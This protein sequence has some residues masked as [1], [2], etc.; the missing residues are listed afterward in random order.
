M[1]KKKRKNIYYAITTGMFMVILIS[2][3]ARAPVK[4]AAERITLKELCAQNNVEWQWDSLSQVVTLNRQ[5]LEA[6]VLIG[7]H[8]VNVRNESI[9]LSAPVR[10]EYGVVIVPPDFKKRVIDK[11][12]KDRPYFPIRK[13]KNIVLDPGH[14]G[15]DPGA[16]GI[17]GLYEKDVVLDIAKRLK[18]NL[19]QN[20]FNV[21]MTRDKDVFIPLDE[22][23]NFA[24]RNKADLFISIHANAA[25]ARGAHGM[26]AYYSKR[27]GQSE[28]REV[29]SSE[30][31]TELFRRLNM[32]RNSLTL[33]NI[34]FDMLYT[35]KQK[36]SELLADFILQDSSKAL[37]MS[38]RG[39]Q[40]ADFRVLRKTLVPAVLVEVGF[41]S[42]KK[43]EKMLMESSYRQRIADRLADSILNYDNK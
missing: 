28:I 25:P 13:F 41:L 8:L 7:S 11:L 18:K 40:A 33:E 34:L 6:R 36:E 10:Q 15:K 26:E 35:N 22:R 29:F 3:C 27:L 23:A 42:N 43:E 19:V 24:S 16:I 4:P 32:E 30:S 38:N 9:A 2:G 12:V 37:E 17:T 20:G 14:G 31:T 1:R 39:S 21:M 5:G